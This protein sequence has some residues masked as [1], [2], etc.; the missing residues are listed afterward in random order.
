MTKFIV[1]T[2]SKGIGRAAVMHWWTM[3]GQ[4]LGS[5]ERRQRTFQDFFETDLAHRGQTQALADH[6]DD[7]AGCWVSST[8]WGSPGMRLVTP[9]TQRCSRRSGT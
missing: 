8:M 5:H 9:S 2:A 4:L 6:L 7:H 3:A 1:V